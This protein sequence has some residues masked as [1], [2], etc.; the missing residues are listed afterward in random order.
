MLTVKLRAVGNLDAQIVPIK[1]DEERDSTNICGKPSFPRSH[2][3]VGYGG[4][5]EPSI[6]YE[7]LYH[8]FLIVLTPL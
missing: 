5:I 7:T 4:R 3:P 6:D 2:R 8:E 1:R